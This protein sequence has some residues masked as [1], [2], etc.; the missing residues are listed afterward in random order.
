[1]EATR[2]RVRDAP[3]PAPIQL[4][5]RRLER[6]FDAT[7]MEPATATPPKRRMK[8]ECGQR[9]GRKIDRLVAAIKAEPTPA[10]IEHQRTCVSACCGPTVVDPPVSVVVT[11][12]GGDDSQGAPSSAADGGISG[13]PN[14]P[15]PTSPATP[16]ATVCASPSPITAAHA[17]AT[18]WDAFSGRAECVNEISEFLQMLDDEPRL[19]SSAM[20]RTLGRVREELEGL[21]EQSALDSQ[22]CIRLQDALVL[23][24]QAMQ[25]LR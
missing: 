7:P 3:K 23:M 6:S 2:Q 22:V 24:T 25:R 14:D 8:G 18:V 10:E 1:Q 15:A 4:H 21:P 16:S 5:R 13:F 17:T 11:P 12:G 20:L 19:R 9:I